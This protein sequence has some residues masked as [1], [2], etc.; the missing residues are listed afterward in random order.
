M[1]L[2]EQF[3]FNKEICFFNHGSYGA[4]PKEIFSAYQEKQRFL[5]FQ[6]IEFFQKHLLPGLEKSRKRIGHFIGA[7]KDNVI[8]VKNATYAA[9]MIIRSL[10]L[11]AGDEIL[12]TNLEYGACLNAWDFWRQEKGFE[13]K[14]VDLEIPLP[15]TDEIVKLFAEKITSN[16]KAI[17]F[18]HITS[19]TAQLLPMEQICQLAKEKNV[20]SIVDGAHAIGQLKLSLE[21]MY[22]D[23]YFGNLH[24]WLYAPKGCAVLYAR[25]SKQHLIKPLITGW[26]WGETREL[27][28]GNDF[29][30]FNQ[31]HGT[32]DLS[33]YLV[34]DDCIDFYEKYEVEK[35][36]IECNKLV[37]YFIEEVEKI[38]GL[39]SLY[40]KF[41]DQ[42][43]LGE[44]QLPDW[45]DVQKFKLDLY[46]KYQIEI[47][48]IKWEDKNLIR[49]SVQIYNTKEEVDYLI[50]ALKEL[51]IK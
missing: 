21:D 51:L 35:R 24:K 36:K 8:M 22:C 41:D 25:R 40:G 13:I 26:G 43:M 49:I 12:I 38:T 50:N 18:S 10:N 30:D 33:S 37:K 32:D 1:K 16:T 11:K 17:F 48:I 29:L 19:A 44:A 9:N 47:P 34:V 20:L 7:D 23:F 2:K 28:T 15:E 27:L 14:Q 6:P 42:L 45:I 5:E 39:P 31:F 4:C 46:D 3:L